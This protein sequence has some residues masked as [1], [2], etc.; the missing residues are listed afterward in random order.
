MRTRLPFLDQCLSALISDIYE[1]NL[2]RKIMVCVVGEFGRTPKIRKGG[3]G[4]SVGRDHWPQAYTALVSGGGMRMGQVIGATNPK[5]EYP[6]QRP[7]SPQDLLATI[8]EHLGI[9]YHDTFSDFFGRPVHILP[10]GKPIG[11][12]A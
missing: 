3:P 10:H 11:E 4:N 6:T 7:T 5:G 8:Y 2:D 1:R 9:N 12:L